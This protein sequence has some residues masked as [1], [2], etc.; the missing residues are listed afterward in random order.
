[1]EKITEIDGLKIRYFDEGSGP[2]VLFL[3]GVSLGSSALVW[4]RILPIIAGAGFRA[5]AYDQPGFGVSDNPN[6]YG[7]PYRMGFICK[8]MDAME[9]SHATI[10]GHSQAGGMVVNLAFQKPSRVT[11]AV[12]VGSERLLPPLPGQTNLDAGHEGPSKLPTLD[13]TR[14]LLEDNLYD[15][16]LITPEVLRQRHEMSIGKNFEAALERIKARQPGRE[17]G[18]LWQRFKDVPV[19][20]LLL[21]GRYDRNMAGERCVLLMKQQPQ[22][23][24]ELIDAAGHL[25]WWDA[26]DEFCEK[27]LG[28]L[29]EE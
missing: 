12:V 15:K 26:P 18:P 17:S 19:P 28:F 11:R 29:R 6:D 3:H 23:R 9:A 13:D 10:V 1:M 14:A 22:L 20:L 4:E 7:V 2:V 21:F 27:V 25:L 5:I 8:F 24:I 16:S